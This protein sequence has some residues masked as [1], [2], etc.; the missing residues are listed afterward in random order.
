VCEGVRYGDV[1]SFTLLRF[2]FEFELL[3]G[4]TLLHVLGLQSM[5]PIDA[6]RVCMTCQVGWDGWYER[7]CKQVD[8][9][10]YSVSLPAVPSFR[11]ATQ[12]VAR[13]RFFFLVFLFSPPSTNSNRSTVTNSLSVMRPHDTIYQVDHT[14]SPQGLS[15]MNP[16]GNL[17]AGTS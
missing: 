6:C 17:A 9:R 4:Y 12:S 7:N 2:E 5:V 15:V 10:L 11:L 1:R 8:S 3:S 16:G 13:Q 14:M